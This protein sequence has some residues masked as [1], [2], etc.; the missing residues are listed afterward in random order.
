MRFPDILLLRKTKLFIGVIL[1][2]IFVDILLRIFVFDSD[3][4]ILV[5]S[6]L[7]NFYLRLTE[8]FANLFLN[9]SGSLV[10]VKNHLAFLNNTHLSNFIPLILFKKWIIFI[11]FLTWVTRTTFSRKAIF[12]LTV[13]LFQFILV[14][15]DIA[16][17]AHLAQFESYNR[18]IMSVSM[19]IGN[20]C[21]ATIL[22]IWY[23]KHRTDILN[24]FSKFKINTDL[25]R[26]K[27]QAIVVITYISIVILHFIMNYFEF[28]LWIKFLFSS[29][30]KILALLGY[31]S[32][33]EPF[34][35]VGEYGSIFMAK[36]CLGYNTMFLFASIIYLTGNDIRRRWIYI[37]F[38]LMILNLA[39]IIRF[40]LL[41]IHI[42]KNG[43][44]TLTM[45]LHNMYN[46]TIY[47][48]VFILWVIW[49]EKFTDIRPVKKKP[50]LNSGN[51]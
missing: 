9:W 10:S 48:L 34:L 13:L 23:W 32:T 24:S 50:D 38:G 42:Q 51:Q 20:L 5:I 16:K 28:E 44:Y 41:F 37:F 11:L 12:T 15:S 2:L 3:P 36:S 14:S 26:N 43:D 19:T 49:F 30:Q 25:L 27:F 21:M 39:N 18:L 29:S 33:V 7:E 1:S 4:L 17:N 46:Y 31:K 47:I 35:L 22:F 8:S 40:V 45:D 6:A